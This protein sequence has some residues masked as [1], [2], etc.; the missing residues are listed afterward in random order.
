MCAS[1]VALPA[2]CPGRI[3]SQH[4]IVLGLYFYL[5]YTYI[6]HYHDQV[7]IYGNRPGSAFRV[8]PAGGP[9]PDS[10]DLRSGSEAHS[11]PAFWQDGQNCGRPLI[12]PS[13]DPAP[14]NLWVMCRCQRASRDILARN[15][16][17]SCWRNS[18]SGRPQCHGGWRSRDQWGGRSRNVS[19]NA[20]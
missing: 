14:S 8:P 7:N 5:K 6:V 11:N 10:L 20:C 2:T 17:A 15:S 16:A 1:C 9:R 3:Y 13:V 18:I 12:F 4:R 19:C